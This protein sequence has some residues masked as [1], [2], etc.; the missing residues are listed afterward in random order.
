MIR[1]VCASAVLALLASS[2]LAAGPQEL[3]ARRH[4]NT[5]QKL[6]EG[7]QWAE[8]LVELRASYDLSPYPAIL[9]RIGLCEEMVGDRDGA[10]ATYRTYLERDPTSQRM[11]AVQERIR[12]LEQA[13]AMNV[14]AP[15]PSL[16]PP[17][18]MLAPP[19][20]GR[21]KKIAGLA[22]VGVGAASLV[23][24]LA[25]TGVAIAA[26]DDL[27]LLQQAH[28][29]FD[30]A[31]QATDQRGRSANTASIALYAVGGAAVVTG[32]IVYGLGARADGRFRFAFAPQIGGGLVA[33]AG[34]F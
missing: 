14:A 23:A 4:Y 25:A 21:G 34:S 19:S 27:R 15:P 9:Y 8:A 30:P 16:P 31:A 22:L 11:A 18:P 17:P 12:I 10:I 28:G 2:G 20:P 33:C 7:A 5:A 29:D 6:M 13:K 3:E 1:V 24:G 32:A 26:A